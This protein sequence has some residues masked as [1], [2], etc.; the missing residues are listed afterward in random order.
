MLVAGTVAGGVGRHVAHLARGL[1]DLGINV[2]VA[3]PEVV[4]AH[5][6]LA[7]TGAQLVAVDI[8][9]RPQPLRDRSTTS[10]LG[11]HAEQVDVVHAHGLRAGA[12]SVLGCGDSS[13][14]P[15]VVTL[16][17]AAPEGRVA[18][19]LHHGL[20]RL[21]C[22]RADLVL[23]VSEDLQRQAE[24]RGGAAVDRAVVAAPRA[25]PVRGRDEVRADLGIP[26]GSAMVVTAGRLAAQKGFDR[27]LE[28]LARP[29]IRDL[30]LRAVIAG[31]GPQRASLQREVE[32]EG[33][34]VQLLGH[35]SDVQDLLGAA[36]LAISTARWEGQ[37]VWLQ[38]AL[39]VGV[40][41]V[42]TDVGGTAQ[43][44]GGG[45]DL[46][47]DEADAVTAALHRAVTDADHRADLRRRSLARAGELPTE[48]DA[49]AAALDAYRRVGEPLSD[50]PPQ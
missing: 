23:A 49:I 18:A 34:P 33:L 43:V 3:C 24:A 6:D 47:P 2:R 46:V 19:A 45:G 40:P 38:E 7:A 20:E 36:D 37:P 41:I 1:T 48:A 13:G 50:P 16:H 9:S 22:S 39:S 31:D 10:T 25:T 5:F 15:V 30:D 14:T 4:A 29:E 12:L 21:V 27:L 26:D 28:V 35:R 8:G 42:A 32:R 44:I 17:N 11:Q